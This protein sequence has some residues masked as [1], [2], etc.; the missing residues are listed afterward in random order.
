M[1]PRVDVHSGAIIDVSPLSQHE[2][3]QMMIR[4]YLTP[5]QIDRTPVDVARTLLATLH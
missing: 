4:F 5:A 3:Y 1:G 2:R